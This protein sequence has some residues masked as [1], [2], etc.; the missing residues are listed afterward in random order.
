MPHLNILKMRKIFFFASLLM[1]LIF[2]ACSKQEKLNLPV[3]YET[4]SHSALLPLEEGRTDSLRI[5]IKVD[6]PT[7]FTD[8]TVLTTIQNSIKMDL[9]GED[10]AQM[11]IRKAVKE[12]ANMLESTYREH[13]LPVVMEEDGFMVEEEANPLNEE[14]VLTGQMMGTFGHILV[15][16][17]ERYIYQGGV[18]G[19]ND[20]FFYNYSLLS[21][22]TISQDS[23]FVPGYETKLTEVLLQNLA[24]NVAGLQLV[25]D[26]PASGYEVESVLPNDNFYLSDS[27]ITFVFNPYEIAPSSYGEVAIDVAWNQVQDI[28]QPEYKQQ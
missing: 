23:I 7:K 20:R 13:N 24:E 14:Q 1:P 8:E 9:F 19:F 25:E 22:K 5:D 6:F 17:I 10:F 27:T 28:L 11:P 3:D 26:L 4:Y 2:V 21:G 18:H 16:S 12:Y 15:Y